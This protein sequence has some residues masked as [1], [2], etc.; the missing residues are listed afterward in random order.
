MIGV[1]AYCRV[2]T[3][4][5]DQVNS[6]EAQKRYFR[7]Y[8]AREPTWELCGIYAD[9]GISGTER[10]KRTAFNRMMRDAAEGRF[11]IILTKEVSRFSRNILDTISCTRQLR[12]CGVGVLFLTDGISTLEPDAEL[13][14]SIMA[15]LAQ[16]ESRKT[17]VRVKWGQTRRMEQG[18][19]FGHSLLGYRVKNG[20][21][22]VREDEAQTVR[23]IFRLYT[24][25]GYS[26]GEIAALLNRAETPKANGESGW[27]SRHILRILKNEK[28]AGDLV[29]KKSCTPDYLSHARKR[30]CGEEKQ[31]VLR[32]HHEAIVPRGLWE[33]TQQEIR[34][35]STGSVGREGGTA[36]SGLSGK[37]C[38]GECGA[39]FVR[40]QKRGAG[41]TTLYRWSCATVVRNGADGERGG[42]GVSRLLREDDAVSMLRQAMASLKIDRKKLAE[43]TACIVQEAIRRG[44]VCEQKAVER[45]QK[46]RPC[47]KLIWGER[48]EKRSC[49]A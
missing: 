38:C 49:R 31:I 10:K 5:T 46:R 34:R 4:Q 3:D 16:E 23:K 8:I 14:L 43:E 48:S 11:R 45:R 39:R 26:S 22:S 2:S 29:Q 28:Y 12:A 47:W 9:E 40:R 17:S 37:I 6:L 19:V 21:M 42:C 1:A 33:L 32:D 18:V 41:G 44:T 25:E 20:S 36:R 27:N 24:E 30:N 35:R 15:S 13:R 7:E